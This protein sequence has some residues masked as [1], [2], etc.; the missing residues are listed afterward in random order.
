[1]AHLCEGPRGVVLVDELQHPD[2]SSP[3]DEGETED[4]VGGVASLETRDLNKIILRKTKK[5]DLLVHLGVEPGIVVDI[6]HIESL[7]SLGDIAGDPLSHREPSME[8][9]LLIN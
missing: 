3:N 5:L 4:G 6:G 9:F 7:T 1:M 8:I 2:Q